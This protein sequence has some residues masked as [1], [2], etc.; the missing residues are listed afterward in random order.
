VTADLA[1]GLDVASR[2]HGLPVARAMEVL[3][4]ML[5]STVAPLA[6]D[7]SRARKAAE[8]RDRH[9]HRTRRPV[10]LGDAT[11]IASVEARDRIATPDPDV[12]AVAKVEGIAVVRLPPTG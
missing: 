4:P 7:V 12:L 2:L 5:G 1:E 11:L 9:D 8:I 6:L 3:E 10:S